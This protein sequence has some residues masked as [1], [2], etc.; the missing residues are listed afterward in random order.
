[1][2][3]GEVVTRWVSELRGRKGVVNRIT[4]LYGK[5]KID[6]LLKHKSLYWNK[7]KARYALSG[8]RLQL[9]AAALVM[10]AS[11]K[12]VPDKVDLVKYKKENGKRISLVEHTSKKV[13]KKNEVGIIPTN[14]A[15]AQNAF[16]ATL[17]NNPSLKAQTAGRRSGVN[18]P[19]RVKIVNINDI[20]LHFD[21]GGVMEANWSLDGTNFCIIG[22]GI[23][24]FREYEE[25]GLVYVDEADG[26][27]K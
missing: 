15:T 11:G 18:L 9:P 7:G 3:E 25:A 17:E 26:K 8:Y 24:I 14:S 21:D 1:M 19:D 4:S 27:K 20:E 5:D 13:S 22:E 6:E 16:G 23:E 2:D 10:R 12:N